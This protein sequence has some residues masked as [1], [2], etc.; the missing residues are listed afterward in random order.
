MPGRA[1]NTP[2]NLRHPDNQRVQHSVGHLPPP[3]N[4]AKQ[5]RGVRPAQGLCRPTIVAPITGALPINFGNSHAQ[6]P[7]ACIAAGSAT[8]GGHQLGAGLGTACCQHMAGSD[9]RNAPLRPLLLPFCYHAAA[10]AAA[11]GRGVRHS[12]SRPSPVWQHTC[13]HVSPAA[14]AAGTQSPAGTIRRGG[15]IGLD[16]S[17]TSSGGD[18]LSSL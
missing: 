9:N 11:G 8:S 16:S 6:L 13:R 17:S 5:A 2:C 3:I 1:S 7:P 18:G 15:S 14:P 12:S 4:A 10:T